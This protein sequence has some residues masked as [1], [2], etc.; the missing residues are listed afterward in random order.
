MNASLCSIASED[1]AVDHSRSNGLLGG[2]VAGFEAF[3]VQEGQQLIAM[4]V[5]VIAKRAAGPASGPRRQRAIEAFLQSPTR[6]RISTV[7]PNTLQ[8]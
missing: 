2:P 1:F 3:F 7:T 5:Q 6:D 8:H 4:F